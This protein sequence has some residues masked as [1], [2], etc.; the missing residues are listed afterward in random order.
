MKRAQKVTKA[1]DQTADA[2]GA[3]SH[4]HVSSLIYFDVDACL[5]FSTILSGMGNTFT[6]FHSSF[7]RARPDRRRVAECSMGSTAGSLRRWRDWSAVAVLALIARKANTA[8][9]RRMLEK[10]MVGP[11]RSGVSSW[12]RA[13]LLVGSQVKGGM[14]DNWGYVVAVA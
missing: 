11:E 2:Q 7:T 5:I 10:A 6:T 8:R 13:L 3:H 4:L 1:T 9:S 14:T 12:T